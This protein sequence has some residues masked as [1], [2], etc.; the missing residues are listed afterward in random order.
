VTTQRQETAELLTNALQSV[1]M[2]APAIL[3]RLASVIDLPD[4]DDF[5]AE[6]KQLLAPQQQPQ[7]EQP[8]PKDI[9][10]A[11]LNAAKAEGQR[12]T[13]LGTAMQ[14]GLGP[15]GAAVQSPDPAMGAMPGAPDADQGSF[16]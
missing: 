3:P 2:L 13:N 16:A 5:A 14:L 7:A 15:M 12:L 6:V 4:A 1:P 8:N 9:T 10:S 11:E